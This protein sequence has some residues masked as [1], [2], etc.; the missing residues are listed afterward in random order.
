MKSIMAGVNIP[1][2]FSY[3]TLIAK[4]TGLICACGGGLSIGREGPFVHI[5]GIIAK[6][7]S[8]LKGFRYLHDNKTIRNQVMGAAVAAGVAATFG[9]P[10][11]GVLFSIEVTAT[12][13]YVSNLW[14]GIFCSMFC[15]IVYTLLK[16]T[17]ITDL[18]NGTNFPKTDLESEVLWFALLGI[19]AGVLGVGFVK[20]S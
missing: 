17:E 2:Y 1:N 20:L 14:K 13:Y 19:L 7:L 4:I 18:V 15:V 11:G 12:Y 16:L 8:K 5:S 9:A 10:M 6:K 3:T